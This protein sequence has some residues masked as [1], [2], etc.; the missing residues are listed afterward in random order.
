MRKIPT[1][2][3]FLADPA[4]VVAGVTRMARRKRA[5]MVRQLIKGLFR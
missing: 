3:D 4:A 5:T 1:Y 2:E